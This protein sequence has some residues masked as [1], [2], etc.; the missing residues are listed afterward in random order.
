VVGSITATDHEQVDVELLEIFRGP[1]KG[2][3]IAGVANDS[4]IMDLTSQT[5]PQR[6]VFLIPLRAGIE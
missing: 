1:S 3:E 5:I 2:V 4:V 6:G